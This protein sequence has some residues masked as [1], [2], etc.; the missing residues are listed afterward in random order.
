MQ[1]YLRW[2]ALFAILSNLLAP[3]VFALPLDVKFNVGVNINI[4]VAKLLELL[5]AEG[6]TAPAATPPS[7]TEETFQLGFTGGAVTKDGSLGLTFATNPV[8]WSGGIA[9]TQNTKLIGNES[10]NVIGNVQH[11]GATS[12]GD[13]PFGRLT[14]FSVTE[15]DV[16]RNGPI[17]H[18]FAFLSGD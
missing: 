2:C 13:P 9:F 18:D 10:F 6:F 7:A 16:E 15:N 8:G 14:S 11:V 3:E 1:Y 5:G 4:D 17:T 12:P